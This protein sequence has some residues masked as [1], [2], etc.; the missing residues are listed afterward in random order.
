M[1]VPVDFLAGPSLKAP[2]D[3]VPSLTNLQKKTGVVHR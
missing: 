2:K 3:L 1:N